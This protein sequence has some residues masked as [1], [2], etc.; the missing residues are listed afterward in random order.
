MRFLVVLLRAVLPFILGSIAIIAWNTAVGRLGYAAGIG[1]DPNPDAEAVARTLAENIFLLCQTTLAGVVGATIATR[2]ARSRPAIHI[3][4]FA[5]IWFAQD[6]VVLTVGPGHVF[7][8]WVKASMLA[9]VLPQLY[10][11]YRLGL[12]WR[13]KSDGPS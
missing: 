10:A 1:A 6:V 7:P 11:G 3:L 9:L 13:S 5:A 4:V 8:L 2:A 12:V